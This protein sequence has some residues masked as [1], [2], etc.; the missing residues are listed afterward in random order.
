MDLKEKEHA[1]MDGIYV[2]QH[3]GHWRAVVKHENSLLT[4][5][6]VCA[7]TNLTI[8]DYLIQAQR[9]ANCVCFDSDTQNCPCD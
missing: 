9:S 1:Y 6:V 8:A 4:D 3:G 7:V 2:V 5:F